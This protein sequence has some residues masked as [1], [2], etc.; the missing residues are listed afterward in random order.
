MT[1]PKSFEFVS[2]QFKPAQRRVYFNY[3]INFFS[4]KPLLFTETIILPKTPQ[5]VPQPLLKNLLSSLHLILGLSYYKLYCPKK[6]IHPYK[7]TSEQAEFFGIVYKKG[8]GEFYYRNHLDPNNSPVFASDNKAQAQA[9]KYP[10]QKRALV[11]IGGGKDSIVVAELMKRAGQKFSSFVME[12]EK[13]SPIIDKT[14][15]ALGT[16]KLAIIRKLDPKIFQTFPEAYNG[17][18]PFSAIVAFMGL[19][20][21]VLYDYGEVVVGNEY[22]SNFGNIKYKGLEI[23]HQWSKSLEFEQLFQNYCRKFI[24]PDIQYYSLLRPY[25]EI[26]IAQMFAQHKKYHHLFSSCNLNFKANKERQKTLWCGE[27]PKCAFVFALLSAYLPKDKVIKIF[28]KNLYADELLL[29]LYQDLIGEGKM[30][31]FECVGTF[32]E[33]KLAMRLASPKFKSDYVIKNLNTK[34]VQSGKLEELLKFQDVKNMPV[35]QRLLGLKNI[36]IMG[37]ENEGKITKQYLAKKYPWLNI[38]IADQKQ[39]KDYLEKQK[40]YDFAIRTPGLTKEKLTIPYTTATNIFLSQISNFTIGVTGT[41]GKSTT[42]SLIYHILKTAGKKVRL[43]GNIGNPMLEVLMKPINPKEIFVLELSS[44]QLDDI[45]YSPNIAV[46]LNLY[47]DHMTYHGGV[48]KY[49]DA[50]RN[51]IKYQSPSDYFIYNSKFAGLKLWAKESIAQIFAYNNGRANYETVLLGKHNQDNIL[52]AV[53]AVKILGISDVIIKKAIKTFRPLSHRLEFVGEYNEIK[54]YDDAI[55]T[56]PE[57]TI[58][59]IKSLPRV[60]TIFLGG[61]DRGYDFKELEGIIIKSGIK[62]VVLFPDSGQRIFKQKNKLNILSTDSMAEAVKFAYVSTKA[63]E[64]CLLSTASPSYSLWKNFEEKGNQ[65]QA[66]I[67]KL[68]KSK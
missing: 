62:N 38:G 59:A 1:K 21:A 17:H 33:I 6:V 44:Y 35:S 53:K 10:R 23:N 64:I 5:S 57:S 63:G 66:I 24:T 8:L 46:V 22:S 12:T 28:G 15:K 40:D 13:G 48:E 25:Y 18:V 31:P 60:G 34:I 56:T 52:A 50:K 7:L 49:H 58:M 14:I 9:I 65:F 68:S 67:K 41:K 11:G 2:Y 54:F 20:G 4:G 42:A 39:G 29:P 32:E 36:L 47:A 55:S 19:L 45:E 26:R 51:I 3:Q 16:D 30:K 61:E 27:C 43:L 37:Y